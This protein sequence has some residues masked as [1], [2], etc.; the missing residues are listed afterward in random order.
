MP[1]IETA[2]GT[3]LFITEW[4]SGAPV[5]FTH[6]WGL[7]SD[8]WDY[9]VPALAEAGLRCVLYDRR[10]HGRSDRPVTGYDFDTLADDLAAVIENLDLRDVTLVGHSLGTRELVRYLTRHGDARVAR[11]V[12]VAPTTPALRRNA[13]NPDGWDPAMID[14]NYA[15]VAANVP[16]WC[17]DFE[18]VGPYFGSSPGSSP[19]LVDWTT[20]MIVDTPLRVLLETL[21]LNTNVNMTEELRKVGVPTLIVQGDQDASAPLELTGRKTA[22]LIDGAELAVYPG[23]G[24]GLYASDHQALNTDIVAF[25]KNRVA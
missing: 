9:Q 13:D 24:H 5:V 4:G 21:K 15:A 25:I 17:A 16:Q 11:M 8:E 18:A 20:R 2:D 10:G 6:A 23:A 12:L 22:A 14:A 19:G 3:S 1:Y 7:R